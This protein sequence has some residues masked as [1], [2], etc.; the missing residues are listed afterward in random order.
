MLLLGFGSNAGLNQL[1]SSNANELLNMLE[2]N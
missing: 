2:K 1:D